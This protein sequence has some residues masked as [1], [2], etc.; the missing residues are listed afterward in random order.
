MPFVKWRG[1]MMTRNVCIA[2]AL[3]SAAACG[4]SASSSSGPPGQTPGNTTPPAGGVSV[5]NNAFDPDAKV[6]ASGT[7]VQWAWNSCTGDGY[8]GTQSCV[9]HN[10]VFDDG[11]T[12]GLKDQGTY[13]RT[14]AVAGTYNYH[15]SIHVAQG[16]VGSV[17]VQ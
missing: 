13:S 15:C 16:M 5:T 6:V 11:T 2:L 12:S 10:I 1:V 9:A 3:I 17:T 14:F 7:S 4:G 8:G